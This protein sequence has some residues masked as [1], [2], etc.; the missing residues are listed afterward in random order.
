[1]PFASKTY[2][3]DFIDTATKIFLGKSLEPNQKCAAKLNH[4][5]VKAPQFSYQRLLGADPVPGIEM[6][7]TGEVACF[8]DNKYEAFLKSMISV[9]PY[10]KLPNKHRT[11][12]L[13]GNVTDSFIPSAKTL[14]EGGYKLYASSHVAP[15][16]DQYGVRHTLLSHK[17]D[18][19]ELINHILHREVDLVINFP[20]HH[21]DPVNFQ[22]RRR[23]VDYGVPCLTN[24]QICGFLA[25]ALT[26]V[27]EMSIKSY[28]DYWPEETI[29]KTTTV[30]VIVLEELMS[31]K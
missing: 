10:F 24:E 3:V 12:L 31:S 23:A 18:D 4:V 9:P 5:A 20:S 15:L 19:S 27:K 22:I 2:D 8:G 26:T 7:S 1:V 11:I 28:A 29:K 6:T 30:D 13:S 25:T 17:E 16:L 21:E 14:V